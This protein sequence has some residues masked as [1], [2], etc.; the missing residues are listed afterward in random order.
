MAQGI[1]LV[2]EN[3]ANGIEAWDEGNPYYLDRGGKKRYARHPEPE[4]ALALGSTRRTFVST[5]VSSSR[6]I[7]RAG[8]TLRQV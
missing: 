8:Q 3:C 1:R 2:C 6:S 7:Q 5:A 4:R